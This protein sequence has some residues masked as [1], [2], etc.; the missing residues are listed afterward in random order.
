MSSTVVSRSYLGVTL[1]EV[2][3][4]LLVLSIGLLGVAALQLSALR[5][6]HNSFLRTQAAISAYAALDILRTRR[7]AAVNFQMEKRCSPSEDLTIRE[8]GEWFEV[9]RQNLGEGSCAEIACRRI[10]IGALPQDICRVT[11]FW[12][13]KHGGDLEEQAF[14]MRTAL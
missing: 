11:I 13:E 7:D 4:T 6:T 1:I 2:L 10:E 12:Q 3:I 5:Q 14:E 9:L 8:L